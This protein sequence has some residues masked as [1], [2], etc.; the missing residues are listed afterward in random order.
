LAVNQPAFT[1]LL[2]FVDFSESFTIGFV[3]IHLNAET[4]LLIEG[5]KNHPIAEETQFEVFNFD[6]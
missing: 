4:D 3:E 6:E 5:L 1:H 2:T